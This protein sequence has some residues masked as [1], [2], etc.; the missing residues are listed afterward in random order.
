MERDC[1]IAHGAAHLMLERLMISSDV[2][3]V[4]VCQDCGFVGY[5]GCVATLWLLM[6]GLTDHAV[7]LVGA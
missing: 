5:N 3:E 2:F 4:D 1:L 7:T 6:T